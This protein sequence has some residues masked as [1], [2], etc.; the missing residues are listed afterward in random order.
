MGLSVINLWNKAAEA[1]S[2]IDMLP[3]KIFQFVH[4][5]LNNIHMNNL[6]ITL[7]ELMFMKN[8][9]KLYKKSRSSCKTQMENGGSRDRGQEFSECIPSALNILKTF[10]RFNRRYLFI[11]LLKASNS[12]L[13]VTFQLSII[14]TFSLRCM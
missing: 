3:R 10:L 6:C 8:K 2:S 11:V 12:I 5:L 14:P 4:L 9:N 7:H 1:A 13:K